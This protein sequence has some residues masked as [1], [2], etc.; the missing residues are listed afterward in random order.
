MQKNL[1]GLLGQWPPF[2]GEPN[3][4]IGLLFGV[5]QLLLPL[6]CF[7]SG[8]PESVTGLTVG[9]FGMSVA[10]IQGVDNLGLTCWLGVRARLG[11][12]NEHENHLHV[13]RVPWP[14][15]RRFFATRR[16]FN[17]WGVRVLLVNGYL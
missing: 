14:P 15:C 6:A 13:V 3:K 11:Q 7:Q 10:P 5:A 9:L 17:A 12:R 2:V 4:E 1:P 8:V 16:S